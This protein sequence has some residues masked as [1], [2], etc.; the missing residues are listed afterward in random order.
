MVKIAGL[1]DF[2]WNVPIH[3]ADQWEVLKREFDVDQLYMCHITGIENKYITE[4]KDLTEVFDENKHLKVIFV[5]ENGEESLH[6]FVHPENALYVFGRTN[7]SPFNNMKR[8][9]DLSLRIDTPTDQG[10]LLSPIVAGIVLYDR[11]KKWR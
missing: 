4:R 1:W 7:L 3:E 5:A 2:S 10:L 6:D 11:F 9:G 8:D